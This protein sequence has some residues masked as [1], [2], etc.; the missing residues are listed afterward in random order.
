V[1]RCLADEDAMVTL[2][3]SRPARTKPALRSDTH[4]NICED[5]PNRRTRLSPE[6]WGKGAWPRCREDDGLW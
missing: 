4:D 1:Y 5:N 2:M 3:L 6:G